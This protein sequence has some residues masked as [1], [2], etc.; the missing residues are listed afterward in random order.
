ML[1]GEQL[2]TEAFRFGSEHLCLQAGS[3][4]A[5]MRVWKRFDHSISATVFHM[6]PPHVQHHFLLV[7][8]HLFQEYSIW[9]PLYNLTISC[10]IR[11]YLTRHHTERCQHVSHSLGD[12]QSKGM[13]RQDLYIY[14][15]DE[16][17]IYFHNPLQ[18]KN[19]NYTIRRQCIRFGPVPSIVHKA[20]IL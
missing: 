1:S 16:T 8:T 11:L 4:K 7:W 13:G 14:T 2:F 12:K 19:K 18:K 5:L 10:N 15:I 6:E 17:W 9:L 3:G 20:A